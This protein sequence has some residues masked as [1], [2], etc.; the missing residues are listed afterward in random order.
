MFLALLKG[1][2][3]RCGA[4]KDEAAGTVKNQS[5]PDFEKIRVGR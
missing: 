5:K 4:T 3:G 1:L 2:L